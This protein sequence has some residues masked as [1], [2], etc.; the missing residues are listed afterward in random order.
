MFRSHEAVNV[1]S[2]PSGLGGILFV[3]D[4]GAMPLAIPFHAFSVKAVLLLTRGLLSSS[5]LRYLAGAFV[6]AAGFPAFRRAGLQS[7][8][9]VTRRACV[10]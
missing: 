6:A 3:I 8:T 4:P 2:A 10:S 9:R 5:A 7:L 1:Y